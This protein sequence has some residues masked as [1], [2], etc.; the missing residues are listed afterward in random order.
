MLMFTLFV[1]LVAI[2]IFLLG[3]ITLLRN[4]H[5]HNLAFFLLSLLASIWTLCNYA[6]GLDLPVSDLLLHLDFSSGILVAWAFWLLAHSFF[7][8]SEKPLFKRLFVLTSFAGSLLIGV[9]SFFN[10][11]FTARPST[12][13]RFDIDYLPPFLIYAIIIVGFIVA[14]II[15]LL[16]AKNRAQ[17]KAKSQLRTILVALVVSSGVITLTNVVLPFFIADHGVTARLQDLSYVSL[18]LFVCITSYAIV[19]QR[20]FDIRL[21]VA[22]SVAY[23]LLLGTLAGVYAA[24]IFA[25]SRVFFPES[26]FGSSEAPVYVLLALLLAFTF[27]PLREFFERITDKLFFRDYYDN[28]AVVN[29][30]T[31]IAASEFHLEKLL[32]QALAELCRSLKVLRGMF[33]IF[34][35]GKIFKVAHFGPLPDRIIVVPELRKLNRTVLVADELAGGERKDIMDHHSIRLSLALRTKEEFVGFL[36][37]GDKLSGDIYTTKDLQLL[38]LL[39]TELAVAISNAKSFEQIAVFNATLQE[40]IARATAK[41][42]VANRN[43][44]ALDRAKDEFISLTSHQLRT[45][46]TTVKG[47]LSM[48]A[49]GDAG[50]VTPAQRQF[51][52]FALEGTQR[53]VGL[54]SDLLNVSRM[55]A[56]RFMLNK[57]PVDLATI[58]A[59]ETR[60]LQSRAAA[61]QLRLSF[62]PPPRK[63]PLVELDEPRTRQVIMNFID[64]AIY[65]TPRGKVEVAVEQIDNQLHFKVADT[66]IGVPKPEQPKLFSKFYRARNAQAIR[67]DGTGLGLYMAK[68]VIEDQGGKI[69]FDSVVNQGSTFGFAMPLSARVHTHRPRAKRPKPVIKV[70]V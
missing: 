22:R 18:L 33:M 6:S 47:Y 26:S 56:G 27:Q 4:R 57:Q 3:L 12:S 21:V 7:S 9:L 38:R 13:G 52:N 70:V 58:V 30:I 64:N 68:R 28:Q 65:Y 53:M 41:L 55:S 17:G 50:E 1:V 34:N 40:R 48:I 16:L 42:R 39:A 37:L 5:N 15:S 29:S 35:Q 61:K 2:S 45:P 23:L 20:L 49:E 54:I 60:Q 10:L 43:L 63:L 14:G 11:F 32:D 62:V 46:L 36:L 25:V 51:L 24:G 19:R 59:D 66:G 69:I 67:P 31:Q 44:K 8:S